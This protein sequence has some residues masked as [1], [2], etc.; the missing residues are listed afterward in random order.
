[1]GIETYEPEEKPVIEEIQKPCLSKVIN[2]TNETILEKLIKK[3]I[4][5]LQIIG[6]CVVVW[7]VMK[8]VVAGVNLVLSIPKL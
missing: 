6:W 3:L 1:M 8:I 7:W 4:L 2:M 5:P